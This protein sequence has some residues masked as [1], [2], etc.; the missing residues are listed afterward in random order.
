MYFIFI[1]HT[2]ERALVCFTLITERLIDTNLCHGSVIV[3]IFGFL[4]A[5]TLRNKR[6]HRF[7]YQNGIERGGTAYFLAG[8]THVHADPPPKK[9]LIRK[10][11][12]VP[13]V[14]NVYT[15]LFVASFVLDWLIV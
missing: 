9:K 12:W 10:I 14:K 7:L 15:L 1:L 5:V 8:G 6:Y 3:V 11:I 4:V 13:I 2:G